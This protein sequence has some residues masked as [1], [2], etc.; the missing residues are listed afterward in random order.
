MSSVNIDKKWLLN[1]CEKELNKYRFQ[2]KAINEKYRKGEV[3]EGSEEDKR[4]NNDYY[5]YDGRIASL[6]KIKS[7]IELMKEPGE[8]KINE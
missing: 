6:V 3:E 4:L 7:R 2:C 1:F 5:W 8:E